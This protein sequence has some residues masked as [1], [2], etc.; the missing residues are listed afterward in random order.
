MRLY[1]E[2]EK[3]SYFYISMYQMKKKCK[4]IYYQFIT[5]LTFD[6]NMHIIF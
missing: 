4:Y 3:A 2:L 6:K 5:L 1:Y